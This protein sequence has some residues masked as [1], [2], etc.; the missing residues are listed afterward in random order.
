MIIILMYIHRALINALSAH[1]IHTNLNMIFCTQA[2]HSPTKTT[3]ALVIVSAAALVAL[4][5][6]IMFQF[7]FLFCF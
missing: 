2:E 5:L 1:V 3:H 4:C 7:L 6:M